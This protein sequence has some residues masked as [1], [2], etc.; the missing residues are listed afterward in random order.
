MLI[1]KPTLIALVFIWAFDSNF[2][3]AQDKDAKPKTGG[4]FEVEAFKNIS[5]FDDK[6]ADPKKHK[7]DL[8]LP[9]GHKNYPVLFFIHGGGWTSGDRWQYGM[10][11]QVFAK[12]GV[13]VV[14]ISYRLS[15]QVQHPGHIED[16]AR[17][18]AWTHKNIEKYGGRADQIFI[19][20][21]SAG[22]HL[23]A[24]LAT[25]EQFLKAQ[26]LSLKN[27]KGAM[28]MSGIYTFEIWRNERVVGKGKEAMESA[29]PIKHI[30]GKEPPFII[31]YAEKDFPGC[32][33]M[34]HDL[35]DAL[36]SKKV[37]AECIEIKDRNHV[38]IMF[39]L[40][41]SETDPTTQALLEFIAK[42]S[43]LKLSLKKE[44]ALI[45]VDQNRV[46]GF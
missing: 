27:I 10:V 6:D 39:K 25:N 29:S 38:S 36:K 13:G 22:G 41:M 45:E 23:T 5:Y 28:P 34:S 26:N 8:F 42:H 24:L 20:G 46:A 32:G 18:F 11:G 17:A 1:F 43:G 14:V 7:L 30:S 15:P 21:Q 44:S 3:L 2:V 33:K 19:S 37:E 4:S 40:M 9:K 12:N 31:L 35:C 16:V